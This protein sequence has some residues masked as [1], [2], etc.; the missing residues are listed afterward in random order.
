MGRQVK[1]GPIVQVVTFLPICRGTILD[2][3]SLK[4]INSMS[5]STNYDDSC[6]SITVNEFPDFKDCR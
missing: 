4:L 6:L 3:T 1:N 2:K 5:I